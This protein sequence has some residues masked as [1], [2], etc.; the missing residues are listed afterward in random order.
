MR[1]DTPAG[2]IFDILSRGGYAAANAALV[3]GRITRDP[4]DDPWWR[5]GWEGLKAYGRGW[6]GTDKTL[7]AQ[8]FKEAEFAK[9]WPEW[10]HQVAGLALEAGLDPTTYVGVGVAGKAGKG[11]RAAVAA[12]KAGKLIDTGLDWAKYAGE[13]AAVI[14]KAKRADSAIRAAMRATGKT[15][16]E[17]AE[18][19]KAGKLAQA[20]AGLRGITFAGKRLPTPL[21][22]Y[23]F[24]ER[25]PTWLAGA[26]EPAAKSPGMRWVENNVP[27]VREAMNKIGQ[28]FTPGDTMLRPL[29]KVGIKARRRGIVEAARLERTLDDIMPGMAK[30]MRRSGDPDAWAR[31]LMEALETPLA[32]P[33]SAQAKRLRAVRE[34]IAGTSAAFPMESGLA[35]MVRAEKQI[36]DEIAEAMMRAGVDEEI[37]RY[38]PR[39][40]EL[41]DRVVD[42]IIEIEDGKVT[43]EKGNFSDFL[44]RKQDKIER[45]KREYLD[46]QRRV[47]KLK[48]A[49]GRIEGHARGIE[50]RTINFHY[51]KRAAKIARRAVVLKRRIERELDDEDEKRI[52]KPREHRDTIRLDLA[53]RGWHARSVLRL[54]GIGK[55]FGDRI[56]FADVNLDISRG[57]RI[58]LV[59][60]NGTGKT[61][62]ME[63]ALGVQPAHDGDVWLSQTASVFYCDQHH[64][65]LQPDM[66]VYDTVAAETDLNRNQVHYLLAELLFKGAAVHKRVGE[67]SGGERTRLVL[68][69]L[70]NTRADLLMLDEPSNH[71]DLPS[72]EVLQEALKAF[73]GAVLF[74]SHDR[75][76]V[77][78]VATDVFELSDGKLVRGGSTM[79][80]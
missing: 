19:W 47:R 56:L 28:A 2:R 74:I 29:A 40:R 48:E 25:F 4:I 49:I 55:A 34:A 70:M 59:G 3:G 60:P 17:V 14:R 20:Q 21:G 7:G 30:A 31:S 13:S 72:I 10:G 44:K 45:Q 80:P 9:E 35:D 24:A 58:A 16:P 68:A 63:I 38:A 27:I 73:S 11:A 62:L 23:R 36:L 75:R 18:I 5:A 41:L 57:Q 53:P 76:L 51:R 6:K 37:A 78:D 12:Q 65:G 39:L 67:L 50:N 71:L 54:E 8:V 64:A 15:A 69:L 1:P 79:L 52:E 33:T 46:Q 61:T 66:S 43:H 42:S 77:R 22:G 26:M 32:R